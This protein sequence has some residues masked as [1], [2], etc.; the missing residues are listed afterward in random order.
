MFI[1]INLANY[2]SYLRCWCN[3][4]AIGAAIEEQSPQY[5]SPASRFKCFSQWV[6][7]DLRALII[8]GTHLLAAFCHYYFALTLAEIHTHTRERASCTKS[9]AL[10]NL[11]NSLRHV[12]EFLMRLVVVVS[13][14]VVIVVLFAISKHTQSAAA[15]MRSPKPTI[16][17]QQQRKK[18]VRSR[19]VLLDNNKTGCEM[20]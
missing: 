3:R 12:I 11:K 4:R 9:V 2:L 8:L 20:S 13:D 14:F 5:L 1:Q 19:Q 10:T 16:N 7:A 6:N 15:A 18:R 17:A